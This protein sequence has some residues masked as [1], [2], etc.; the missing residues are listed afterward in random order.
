MLGN[1]TGLQQS[2]VDTNVVDGID[3]TYSIT[4]YDRGVKPDSLQYG[5]FGAWDE[6]TTTITNDWDSEKWL[7]NVPAHIFTESMEADS[8]YFYI[9]SSNGLFKI[10]HEGEQ[11]NKISTRK[12]KKIQIVNGTIWGIEHSLWWIDLEENEF[13]YENGITDFFLYEDF[14]WT[15]NGSEINLS[16]S[17]T[18]QEWDIPLERGMEGARIY[19]LSCDDEWVWFLTNNGIIFYNWTIYNNAQN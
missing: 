2:I 9:S 3:Y 18:Y 4:A 14:V 6:T 13:K 5:R 7:A 19:S 8:F 11:I 10:G 16:N 15:T 12:F 1:N 17:S